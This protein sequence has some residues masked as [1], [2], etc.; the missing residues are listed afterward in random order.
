MPP[1]PNREGP[2]R[3]LGKDRRS[4]HG[5]QVDRE[6]VRRREGPRPY[7]SDKPQRREGHVVLGDLD[8]TTQRVAKLFGPFEDPGNIERQ[9]CPPGR[10]APDA[11][12]LAGLGGDGGVDEGRQL[13]P[14]RHL[15]EGV[16]VEAGS[17]L[18]PEKGRSDPETNARRR[19]AQAHAPAQVRGVR[20]LRDPG[21]IH[22][23]LDAVSGCRIPDGA[24]DF[25]DDAA[26]EPRPGHPVADRVHR[27]F[28]GGAATVPG[29]GEGVRDDLDRSVVDAPDGVDAGQDAT[30]DEGQRRVGPQGARGVE[31]LHH[32]GIPAEPRQRRRLE[33]LSAFPLRPEFVGDEAPDKIGRP[34]IASVHAGVRGEVVE[35]HDQ[36]DGEPGLDQVFA[37]DQRKE[38][39]AAVEPE[40]E[41]SRRGAATG[42][43]WMVLFHRQFTAANRGRRETRPHRLLPDP[44]SKGLPRKGRGSSPPAA[45]AFALHSS[46]HTRQG[47]SRT[48]PAPGGTS[49][50][51]L[52]HALRRWRRRGGETASGPAR[53]PTPPPPAPRR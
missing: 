35:G 37:L 24:P 41:K 15:D 45:S 49:R 2:E 13:R 7:A 18:E 47:R 22:H 14:G 32:P 10:C 38:F 30:Q 34:A 43:T 6:G 12:C 29:F 53:P 9:H 28:P 52:P 46:R 25:L 51:G 33:R 5:P 3:R 4:Q 40:N 50:R 23:D 8:R 26:P 21:R 20:P 42:E 1:N 31:Y 27:V 11:Q 39:L 36:F 16:G 48:P 17:R 19:R 44:G